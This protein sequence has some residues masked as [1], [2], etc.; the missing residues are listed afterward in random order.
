MGLDEGAVGKVQGKVERQLRRE[1]RALRLRPEPRPESSA[2]L[3]VLAALFPPRTPVP[4]DLALARRGG[5]VALE[6]VVE[7][8][9][10]WK[11]GLACGR[12]GVI[13]FDGGGPRN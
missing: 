3:A 12:D 6:D 13:Q 10:Q 1:L 8:P 2:R 11:P 5:Q 7:R 4:R 9:E